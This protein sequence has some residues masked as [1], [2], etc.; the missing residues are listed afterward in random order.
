[1]VGLDFVSGKHYNLAEGVKKMIGSLGFWEILLIILIVAVLFGGKKLAQ[2]GKG[3]G[4]G[5]V[6]FKASLK[7]DP[8]KQEKES[9]SNNEK[10]N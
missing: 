5:I 10:N 8:D 2:L 7:K 3:L 6:N 9:D 4:E 1:M